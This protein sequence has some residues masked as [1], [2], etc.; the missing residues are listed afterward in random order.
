MSGFVKDPFSITGLARGGAT[1]V[2][3]PPGGKMLLNPLG[4]AGGGMPQQQ[5]APKPPL[6]PA[7]QPAMP[8]APPH[9]AP[10]LKTAFAAAFDAG[11]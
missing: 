6:V 9:L 7:V 2:N 10:S 3:A 8:N 5:A 1:N 11:C 4:Q